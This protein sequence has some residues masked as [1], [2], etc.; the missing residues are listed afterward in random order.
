MTAWSTLSLAMLTAALVVTTAYLV[1]RTRE[2]IRQEQLAAAHDLAE[3]RKTTELAQR[4]IEA[5]YRP[6][7]I[8]VSRWGLIDPSMGVEPGTGTPASWQ[9]EGT[10]HLIKVKHRLQVHEIDPRRVWVDVQGDD[11][12]LSIPLRNV[13][14]GV[15]LIDA[16]KIEAT[17]SGLEA[18]RARR[19]RPER[20]P[21][22]ET[23]RVNITFQVDPDYISTLAVTGV[24]KWQVIVPY[25]DFVGG[26]GT[27]AI[28][29]VRAMEGADL[30]RADTW[31][32]AD[33][34]LQTREA[35]PDQNSS[36]PSA[37]D[38]G[39]SPPAGQ[40]S[41]LPDKSGLQRWREKRQAS[42][43]HSAGS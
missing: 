33:V 16:S 7:L 11:L 25:T 20:L 3:A 2:G 31:Y 8:D 18:I 29:T 14:Q 28:V 24:G 9:R 36:E 40:H 21:A 22:G 23:G 32:V 42:R 12:L 41:R 13:G 5:T 27:Q 26:Q 39:A 35:N 6:L 17:G 15:A 19:A 10:Q 30:D 34:Q 43:Q 38:P 1:H 37:Q 4:Q